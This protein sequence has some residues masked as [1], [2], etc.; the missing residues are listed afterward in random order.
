MHQVISLT[1]DI[2][3]SAGSYDY[4]I[5]IW[6]VSSYKEEIPP[7]KKDFA[8]F[9]LLKLKDKDETVRW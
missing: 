5:R 9:S 4:T 8:V 7:L 1:N 3:V 2:F 6:N